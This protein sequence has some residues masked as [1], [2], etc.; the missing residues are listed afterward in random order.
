MKRGK[1]GLITVIA[2]MVLLAGVLLPQDLAAQNYKFY[3]VCRF[4]V[5]DV[6]K[7][8]YAAA[9]I[10]GK[11]VGAQVIWVAP[12]SQTVEDQVNM[13][14]QTIA[15]KPDGIALMLSE[16]EPFDEVCRAAIA[17]G[18]PIVTFN[19]GDPRPKGQAIPFLSY[20]GADL[21]GSGVANG[22]QILK[23]YKGKP[24]RVVFCNSLPGH[25]ALDARQKGVLDVMKQAG[26]AAEGL[27]VGG[28]MTKVAQNVQA[29]ITKHP[30]TDVLVGSWSGVTS[31]ILNAQADGTVSSKIA[32]TSF[33][34]ADDILAAIKAGKV[35][36]TIDQQPFLQGYEPVHQLYLYVKYGVSPDSFVAS[37]PASVDASNIDVVMANRKLGYR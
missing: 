19:T 20:V 4:P 11:E 5:T 18:I 36:L 3:F 17:K 21:Y 14:T 15:S 30:D 31:A 9:Q 23:L 22:E 1:L 10:A 7:T 26:V 25:Y 32:V 8:V 12:A 27:D 29:Y 2:A 13:L 16:T 24:R 37:G 33:D 28:E 6:F 35:L 34:I